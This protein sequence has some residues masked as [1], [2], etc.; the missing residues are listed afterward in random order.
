MG[1]EAKEREYGFCKIL[2]RTYFLDLIN[3]K[4]L[5]KLPNVKDEL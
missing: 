4:F 2:V 3:L 5:K 1:E